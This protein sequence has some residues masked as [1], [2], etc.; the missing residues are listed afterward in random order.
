MQDESEQN[1][2]QIAVAISVLNGVK[3]DV[4]EIKRMLQQDYVRVERFIALD[5]KVKDI[6]DESVWL[7]RAIVSTIIGLVLTFISQLIIK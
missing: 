5:D 4:I 2:R 6:K 1:G 3:D 7:K